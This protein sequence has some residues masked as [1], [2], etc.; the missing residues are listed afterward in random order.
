M[1]NLLLGLVVVA[2][3]GA[4]A[5]GA[6]LVASSTAMDDG[7]LIGRDYP[8]HFA[9]PNS[10]WAGKEYFDCIASG[11]NYYYRGESVCEHPRT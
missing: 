2:N 7:L 6:G 8:R 3:L 10:H 11:G 5:F 4:V 9:E 1:K